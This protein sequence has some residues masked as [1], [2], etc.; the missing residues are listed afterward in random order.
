MSFLSIVNAA[1][2][3]LELRGPC[4]HTLAMLYNVMHSIHLQVTELATCDVT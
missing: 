2:S 1:V 4:A 3:K